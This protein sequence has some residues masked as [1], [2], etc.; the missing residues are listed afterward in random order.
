M[1]TLADRSLELQVR[2]RVRFGVG[3]I[4]G[5]PE[6]LASAGGGRPCVISY[7]PI[8]RIALVEAS[9]LGFTRTPEWCM[10]FA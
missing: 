10:M 9:D 8:I 7:A 2:G 4:E 5:L 3:A 1:S 6:L